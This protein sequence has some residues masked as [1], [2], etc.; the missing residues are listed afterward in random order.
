MIRV[1]RWLFGWRQREQAYL[2]TIKELAT[3]IVA[4]DISVRLMCEKFGLELSDR[5]L[6]NS[7]TLAPLSEGSRK[8]LALLD[9]RV[10]MSRIEFMLS[11][12]HLPS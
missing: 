3:F 9:Q 4:S 1:W 11:N 2:E 8:A 5:P 7:D 6:M 10:A 12:K